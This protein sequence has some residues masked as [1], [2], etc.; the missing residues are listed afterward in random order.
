MGY[1]TESD[2]VQR[3]TDGAKYLFRRV[4]L[5]YSTYYHILHILFLH[6]LNFFLMSLWNKFSCQC[7]CSATV[8]LA[9]MI[10]IRK[11]SL[12]VDQFL[13]VPAA[14]LLLKSRIR[15][16]YRLHQALIFNPKL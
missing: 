16:V 4:I 12:I 11:R 1:V 15:Y 2:W 5:I 13:E 9:L 10:K 14:E 7:F 3:D 8:F 6:S